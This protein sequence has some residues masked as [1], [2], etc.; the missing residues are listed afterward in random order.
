MPGKYC[1]R[2]CF[3]V[4]HISSFLTLFF[5]SFFLKF[6]KYGATPSLFSYDGEME[7]QLLTFANGLDMFA[8]LRCRADSFV[9]TW[10]KSL[11]KC[12]DGVSPKS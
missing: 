11:Q 12:V 6:E 7:R 10:I 9:R 4:S 3:N 8:N 2:Y 1:T 5:S